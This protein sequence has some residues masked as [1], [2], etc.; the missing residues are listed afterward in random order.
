MPFWDV[1][2]C[3]KPF[4]HPPFL[5]ISNQ[6]VS[7]LSIFRHPSY[8]S[9][10]SYPAFSR[11]HAPGE[12]HAEIKY[13]TKK[14]YLPKQFFRVFCLLLFLLFC[15]VVGLSPKIYL[16][17]SLLQ[18]SNVTML[19]VSKDYI[20]S[21]LNLIFWTFIDIILAPFSWNIEFLFNFSFDIFFWVFTSN[22]YSSKS[23]FLLSEIS[24]TNFDIFLR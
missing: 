4:S 6:S 12:L 9:F 23:K 19:H 16:H 11:E 22:D 14:F 8:L 18:F 24:S 13:V 17:F 21:V 2:V 5:C 20:Y 3:Q 1:S 15:C 7:L 10:S